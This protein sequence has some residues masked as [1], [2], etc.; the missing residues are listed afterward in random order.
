MTSLLN[1]HKC[2]A[3]VTVHVWKPFRSDYCT[4]FQSCRVDLSLS[5]YLTQWQRA[6][7][8]INLNSTRGT[9]KDSTFFYI[10]LNLSSSSI[11]RMYV[12]LF[13]FVAKDGNAKQF[14]SNQLEYRHLSFT[15]V[16]RCLT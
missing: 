12:E 16:W 14:N 6:E 15:L 2:P 7:N 1:R 11:T 5:K 10:E 9:M 13:R 3:H 4:A 8:E